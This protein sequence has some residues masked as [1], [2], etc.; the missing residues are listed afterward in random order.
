M[1]MMTM[2]NR[3]LVLMALVLAAATAATVATV[4][5]GS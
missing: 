3:A 2:K 4:L 1:D 5:A